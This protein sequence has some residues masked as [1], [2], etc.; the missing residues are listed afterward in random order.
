MK[1]RKKSKKEIVLLREGGK[2]LAEALSVAADI[3][4]EGAKRKVTTKELDRAA[5]KIVRKYGGEPAFLN[6]QPSDYETSFPAAL[7]T[8]INDEIVHGIPNDNVVLHEG[9]IV[10]LDL[11]V[12]FKG[13]FTD[14]A[15]TVAVGKVNKETRKLL[16]MTRKSLEIGIEKLQPGLTLGDY[17][18]AVDSFAHNNGFVTVWGLVGH[19]VGYSQHEDPQIPN[20][21][22][23]GKGLLLESGMV[24][25]LEPMLTLKSRDIVLSTNGYTFSTKDG[26]IA[27]H[28]EHTV[29]ITDSGNEVLTSRKGEII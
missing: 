25:A 4:K 20:Y 28:F 29:A 5:E 6:Y 1:I 8:S 17:G 24:L 23:P 9:D 2:I 3:A 13:L 15:L 26:N 7:C 10:S 14:S 16:D 11:G 21:G 19:G 27:A 18:H 22:T 12:E